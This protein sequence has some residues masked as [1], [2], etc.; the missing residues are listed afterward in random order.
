MIEVEM[1]R[2]KAQLGLLVVLS[3][4]I[5]GQSKLTVE[6][7]VSFVKSSVQLRHDDRQ[8]AAYIK[9]NVK[10]SNRLDARMV[11]ELQGMGAGPQTVA[12][13]K[14]LITESA[15]LEAPPPPAPKLVVSGPPPPDSIE[16][17]RIL[18]E[19][20]ESARNYTKNLPNF[21]C[22]QVTRRYADNS[23][24]D[25][26][27]LI[28]TIA[29]R[30][31]YFE[32]KEDYKVVSVNGVPVTGSVKHEQKNGA[33]SSGEFGS[34]LKEIFDPETQTEFNWE[35]WATLRGKRMYVFNFHVR[36]LNSKYTIYADAV[37]RTI[38][39]GYHGLVYADRDNNLVM[40]IKMEVEDLPVDFP[41]QSVELDMNYDFTKISGQEY[42]LPL[43]SQIRSREGKFMVKNEVEFRLY[44]RFGADTN[45]QFGD[46]PDALPEDATK[47]QPPK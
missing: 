29:E 23:G 46:V 37:K 24:L 31:S 34:I 16:Q 11:E 27:R 13:L 1:K 9:K 36:Q 41:V 18:A 3:V 42:L 43:K 38:V 20:T 21:I 6:Q 5:E 7:L 10:L 35:R 28:D 39:A 33:S 47:E 17:K 32:Q 44:N 30:L 22:L 15:A 4:G 25:N 14:S 45:I 19:I 12:A 2:W 40:R 26:F 8:I